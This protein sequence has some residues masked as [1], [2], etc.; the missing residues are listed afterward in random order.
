MGL[1]L[2]VGIPVSA[3]APDAVTGLVAGV[4][5]GG[6]AALRAD[7]P[8][9]VE[10]ARARGVAVSAY[11]FVMVRI[12]ADV[13]AAARTRRSRSRASGSPTTSPNGGGSGRGIA[14]SRMTLTRFGRFDDDGSR[15]RH[16]ATRHPA[17][18]GSTTSAARSSSRSISNT[19]GGYSFFRDARLRRLTRYRYNN[20]PPTAAAASSTCATRDSGA[21]WSPS[22]QPDADRAGGLPVPPRPRVHRDRVRQR[23][24]RREPVPRASRR[25]LEI[26][27]TRVTNH[28]ADAASA[29]A[30][31]RRRVLPVGRVGR[32]DEL[33]AQP[34]DRRGEVDGRVDLHTTEYRERREPLRLLRLLGAARRVRHQREAFLGPD[35]GWDRP[36]AV[37]AGD[38]ANSIA[39]GWAPIGSHQVRS[40][41]APGETREIIFVL[42]YWENP[43]DA[44]FDPPGIGDAGQAARPPGDRTLPASGERGRRSARRG[45]ASGGRRSSTAAG[46]RRPMRTSTASPTS[47]TPTSAW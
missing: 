22:W 4:G 37:E 40:T 34:L 5:A 45:S 43:A 32:P 12:G 10:G 44:K 24:S 31:Q 42:G 13:D 25:D 35:R 11:A 7:Q 1:S 8:H 47:G 38:R 41:L 46:R 2:L 28:R 3:L 39:H 17:A 21:F 9:G 19:A 27:R 16:H 14:R 23:A 18:R 29:L 33:P 30:V 6:I 20:G 36:A 26:W 15:V